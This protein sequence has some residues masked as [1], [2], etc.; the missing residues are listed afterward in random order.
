VI[1]GLAY[2][3]VL[4]CGDRYD[5]SVIQCH[6]ESNHSACFWPKQLCKNYGL[7]HHLL[8]TAV[9]IDWQCVIQLAHWPA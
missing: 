3:D 9:V 2:S 7:M 8:I 1:F 4:S 6:Y 5:M